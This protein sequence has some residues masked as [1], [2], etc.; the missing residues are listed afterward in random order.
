MQLVLIAVM[1]SFW[2]L[3]ASTSAQASPAVPG[4]AQ[5]EPQRSEASVHFHQGVAF[6]HEGDYR[7]AR[8]EFA[9]AYEISP[10]YRTLYN[11]GNCSFA[12][13]DYVKAVRELESYLRDG[14]QAIEAGRRAEV[15]SILTSLRSRTGTIDVYVNVDGTQVLVDSQLVG[16]SPLTSPVVVNVGTHTV[17][18][19]AA[20]GSQAEGQ[21]VL[22]AGGDNKH[23]L[24]WVSGLS[25]EQLAQARAENTR[26][27]ERITTRRLW[28]VGLF[29]GAG[30]AAAGSATTFLLGLRAR[31]E[32]AR[33]RARE[34]RDES[35]VD[36]AVRKLHVL[37]IS[38]GVLGGLTLVSGGLSTLLVLST[39]SDGTPLERTRGTTGR[40]APPPASR[41]TL[42]VGFGRLGVTAV[43]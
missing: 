25:A 5:L 32:A 8:V 22:V 4:E 21:E 24:L 42:N 6:Y 3:A 36:R 26:R 17:S 18:A 37:N 2:C 34:T 29:V 11:L 23:V 27:Q 43:F 12:L 9:R 28:A 30:V 33:A 13:G 16:V 7:S 1:T 20:D 39:L 10:H 15:E 38:A 14:G 19:R 40:P 35:D 31:D 41:V